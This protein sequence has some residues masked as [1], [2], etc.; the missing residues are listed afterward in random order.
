MVTFV[1]SHFAISP[2]SRYFAS[3]DGEE[4]G[5]LKGAGRNSYLLHPG[6][7]TVRQNRAYD[8]RFEVNGSGPV[9]CSDQLT[10]S[11]LANAPSFPSDGTNLSN[12]FSRETA[13]CLVAENKVS[14]PHR[15]ILFF[16]PGLTHLK[17]V[18]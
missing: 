10:R 3:F 1:S 11:G 4:V 12:L 7:F 14:I 2:L 6:T 15:G 5:N 13:T 8:I 9:I 16:V 18:K 17:V